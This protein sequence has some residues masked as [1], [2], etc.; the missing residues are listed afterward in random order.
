[1]CSTRSMFSVSRLLASHFP[2]DQFHDIPFRGSTIDTPCCPFHT[3]GLYNYLSAIRRAFFA[4]T[5]DGDGAADDDLLQQQLP[6]R[7]RVPLE[8]TD[9]T[10]W[11]LEN[12]LLMRILTETIFTSLYYYYERRPDE[13]ADG[14]VPCENPSC[15]RH[16]STR[17]TPTVDGPFAT[18]RGMR[19]SII[20]DDHE[21]RIAARSMFCS[22]DPFPDIRL[23]CSY[24][25]YLQCGDTVMGPGSCAPL[26]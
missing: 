20:L 11:R 1:M 4:A 16:V 2:P 23:F 10:L 22:P 21:T 7:M 15:T 3:H 12:E 5:A 13:A 19:P 9:A 25:C 17:R 14:R 24:P 8:R 26:N 6:A 18:V